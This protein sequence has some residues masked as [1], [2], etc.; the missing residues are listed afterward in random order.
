MGS[1]LAVHGGVLPGDGE[2]EARPGAP[3]LLGTQSSCVR[4]QETPQAKLLSWPQEE[5]VGAP[6]RLPVP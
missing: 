3:V 6:H 1:L 5:K 2:G 4:T